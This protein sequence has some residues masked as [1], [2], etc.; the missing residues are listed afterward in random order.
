MSIQLFIE[1]AKKLN[2]VA[3]PIKA[4]LL[5]ALALSKTQRRASFCINKND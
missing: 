3:I 5:S 1:C 2:Y 4:V